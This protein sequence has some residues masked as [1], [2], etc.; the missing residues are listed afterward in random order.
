VDSKLFGLVEAHGRGVSGESLDSPS[1]IQAEEYNSGPARARALVVCLLA[2]KE[3]RFLRN[4]EPLFLKNLGA[5]PLRTINT[6]IMYSLRPHVGQHFQ[7][8]LTESVP[9][10]VSWC[11]TRQLRIG[12]RLPRLMAGYGDG[13]KEAFPGVLKPPDTAGGARGRWER[14]LLQ[15]FKRFREAAAELKLIAPEFEKR[16]G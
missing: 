11:R 8:A 10:F 15:V 9:I 6:A 7:I 2:L 4:G 16:W 12:K 14:G 3:P 5:E 1:D 13:G